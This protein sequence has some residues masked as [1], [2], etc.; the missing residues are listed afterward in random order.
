MTI[1]SVESV[2]AAERKIVFLLA[3]VQFINI[4]D[5]M[6][7][8][9]LGP[10]FAAALGMSLSSL[11]LVGGAYTAAAAVAGII[12]STFLDR[13]DR[14]KALAVALLGLVVGTLAGALAQ[15]FGTLVL[16]RVVA[17]AFGGPATA[18]ALSILADVVP[19]QRRGKAMGAVMGAFA[20]A[21]VLGVP[22]GLELAHRGGWRMPFF[23][24]SALGL[25]VIVI[26]MAVMPPMRAHL[27]RDP[28][29]GRRPV[30]DFLA[31]PLVR[32]SLTATA[33]AFMGTFALIPNL[34]SYFQYN[35]GY[36]RER[37]GMLYMVGG[38]VSFIAMR[39]GGAMVDKGGP[40]IVTV[41]GSLCMIGVLTFGFLPTHPVLPVLVMFVT[42]ML[43]NSI[44]SV[45][46]NTISSKVPN[47][48]ERGRFMAA[49]SAV[50]HIAAALGAG[51]SSLL[52]VEAA[53]HKL[54]GMS[55]LVAMALVLTS[56]LP[57]VVWQIHRRLG[58]RSLAVA[59]TPSA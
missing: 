21:S 46:L 30:R 55:G 37:L 29:A 22:A 31:D 15:G 52:L 27:G 38:V 50:Q 19:P 43:A 42:L 26:A 39:V 32:L 1:G 34:A 18:I 11:G 12:A 8:M 6:M 36:P 2:P 20:A 48:A 3:S 47:P 4:L 41:V 28:N 59:V 33:V 16:A 40:N 25:V 58:L 5:F 56:V 53:D 54:A 49:Q 14:R 44:R 10:D 17:G 13:F 23:A 57:F 9:P 24:V 51:V 7:V 45:A 35:L